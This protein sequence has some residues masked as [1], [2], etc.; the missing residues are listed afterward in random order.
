MLHVPF[1]FIP[2]KRWLAKITGCL[3]EDLIDKVVTRIGI[4]IQANAAKFN[5]GFYKNTCAN[6]YMAINTKQM[7][8]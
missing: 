6:I 8:S 7:H 2:K 3:F 4:K 1:F 5:L